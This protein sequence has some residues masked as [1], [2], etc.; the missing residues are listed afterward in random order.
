MGQAFGGGSA[1]IATSVRDSS[2]LTI[3]QLTCS[4]LTIG[5]APGRVELTPQKAIL[6]DLTP[7]AMLGGGARR[8]TSSPAPSGALR[9]EHATVRVACATLAGAGAGVR[10]LI[11]ARR[12]AIRSVAVKHQ[13]GRIRWWPPS[14]NPNCLDLLVEHEPDSLPDFPAELERAVGQRVA[15]YAANQIPQEAW[16]SI[17]VEPITL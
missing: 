2:K 4:Q 10:H 13:V 7:A 12:Q 5:L 3:P 11:D 17:L 6:I 1:P 8:E 9:A 16:G 15:V 14:E